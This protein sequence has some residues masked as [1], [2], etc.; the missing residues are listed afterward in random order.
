MVFGSLSAAGGFQGPLASYVAL[1]AVATLAISFIINLWA[2][3]NSALVAL[4]GLL[5]I[6]TSSDELLILFV[7]FVPAIGMLE[8]GRLLFG[9]SSNH[10]RILYCLLVIVQQIV[11][12][13][14]AYC[15]WVLHQGNTGGDAYLMNNT[16]SPHQL[17][18]ATSGFYSQDPFAA[19]YQPPR[20]PGLGEAADLGLPATHVT[21]GTGV[22]DISSGSQPNSAA[23]TPEMPGGAID[24]QYSHM[25]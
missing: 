5:S 8:L 3:S 15:G 24:N 10:L 22:A 9:S 18:G 2:F 17:Y 13:A 7:W 25:T 11:Q 12:F 4:L 21:Y 19:T 23:V 14:G 20:Q 6:Y 1:S 16:N